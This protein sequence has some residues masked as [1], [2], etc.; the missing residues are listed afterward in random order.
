MASTMFSIFSLFFF[1]F[2]FFFFL[3]GGWAQYVNIETPLQTYTVLILVLVLSLIDI[4]PQS[5][6]LTTFL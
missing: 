4:N 5:I 1:L 2:F 3:G 6:Y